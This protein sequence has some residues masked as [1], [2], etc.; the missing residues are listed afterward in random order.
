MR[1]KVKRIANFGRQTMLATL[2][3]FACRCA[4]VANSEVWQTLDSL[5]RFQSPALTIQVPK[6]VRAS[7]GTLTRTAK[8]HECR[9]LIIRLSSADFNKGVHHERETTKGT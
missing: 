3:I 4:E 5:V 1:N 8:P 9:S 6:E 7:I 2:L